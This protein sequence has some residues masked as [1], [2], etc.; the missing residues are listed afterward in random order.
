M[1]QNSAFRMPSLIALRAFEALVRQG[2]IG[3]AALELHVT[4]GA[5]SHQVK[6]LE[7][8]LGVALVERQGKGV[9]LTPAGRQ[10]SQQISSAFDQ[11]RDIRRA[12][13]NEEPAGELRIA[14]A[15]ALLARVS[16]LLE[17]FLRNYQEVA[18]H[19]LPMSS[20][21]GDVDMVISFG[22][23]HIEG[24]R[25]AALGD[26]RYFPVCSPRLLNTQDHLRKP[27]DLARQV[28]LHEDDGFDWSRYF[29]AAGIPGLQARQNVFLPDAYLTIRAAIAGGGVTISDHI[30]A[31][32]E[33]HQGRL[34]RLFDVD[35]PA[36]HP[37][38]LIIPPH[39][40][41]ALAQE[42]ADWLLRELE[43]IPAFD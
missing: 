22:E 18:L 8:E 29:L 31:G 34:V 33:L 2:S 21:L 7:E 4:H 9:K 17:K 39:G 10:L 1:R 5:V 38:F 32:E 35:F 16:S 26:I 30:L 41:Q 6:K 28:L 27:R 20:D 42:F 15:P 13:P 37:Y 40:H 24:Q 36:P 11:L 3:R 12:L 19:L 23:T 14:C 25:F 43:A